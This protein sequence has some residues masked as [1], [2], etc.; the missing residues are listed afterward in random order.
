MC[1]LF[2]NDN[3]KLGV[4]GGGQLG[5]MLIQEAINYDVF[6]AVLDPASKAPCSAIANEFVQGSFDDFDTVYAFG[7]DKSVLTIEIE[8]VNVDALAK[9]EKEGVKVFPQSSILRVIKDKGLQKKFYQDNQIK[10][11]DF[12]LVESLED[13]KAKNLK[14]PFVQ[15]LRTGGYDG[16][17][18]QVIRSEEELSDAF[19][20]PSVI[21]ELIDFEKEIAVIA[22]RNESGELAIYP[23]VDMEFNSQANLVEFL[24]S[25]AS[26]TQEVENKAFE[27]AAQV[28]E[29]FRFVGLLAI[30]MFVTKSG[31]VLVNEV[32]PRPHNSGHHT[33]EGNY[34]SQYEQHLRSILNL[35]LGST[36]IIK[37]AVMLNLLGEPD[38]QGN[39]FYQGLDEVIKIKGANVHIYG[40]KQT[41][42]FRKM[43]HIT[44]IDDTLQKAKEKAF[45]IKKMIQVV[46][47]S[48]K[49]Q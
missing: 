17:G 40:K 24:F 2:Y 44:I 42:P 43:G 15:K 21:E 19:D 20:A 23:V 41:K 31:E 8:H 34:T 25:P 10:T 49:N 39:V 45:A 11:A 7:K 14:F 12:F 4:L 36:E 46:A 48:R 3:F 38:A 35:P 47:H 16:K 26:L 28:A 9:L 13:L 5:R 22:A 18:V 30:E 6:V 27:L 37:P 1:I 32:A 29:S 33:I